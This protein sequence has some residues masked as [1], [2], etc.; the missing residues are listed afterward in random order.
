V[1]TVL[2]QGSPLPAPVVLTP[3][4]TNPAGGLEQ[5]ERYEGMRVQVDSL[6]VV[7]P[8][9]GS[10]SEASALGFSNGVFYGVLTGVARPFR[11]PGIDQID[12]LPPGSPCCVPRF[13]TNPERLRVDSDALGAP[14]L[15]VTS[16][17]VVSNLVGELDYAFRTWTIL[18][19]P[20]G[21]PTVTGITSATPVPAA[22]INEFTIASFNMQRFYDTT[23]DPDTSDGVL[24]ATGLERRLQKASLA[25]RNV[26]RM[27]DIIGVQEVENL[28]TL[29]TLA[30]RINSD[31][32]AAGQPN[33]NYIPYLEE[34]NDIGGIDV[35]LLVKL[36]RVAVIEVI[37]EGKDATYI[38]PNNGQSELLNDRPP[39]VLRA[40]ILS[41]PAPN[42]PI[43]AIVNHLRSFLDINDP[44]DG[45]RV[46]T[47]RRAQAEF[48]ANL[49]QARQAADPNE[50]IVL[51]GDFNSYQFSDGY[52]D[53][54]GIIRGSPASDDQVVLGSTD[55]VD[56]DLINLVDRADAAERYSYVFDGSA[57]VLD[58]ILMTSNM[59]DSFSRFHYARNDADFPESYR[60]DQ[61]R[62][63]RISDH[64]MPV[65]YFFLPPIEVQV[66]IKPGTSPNTIN[67]GSKGTVPVAILSTPEFDAGQVDPSTVTLASAPV[68]LKGNGMPQA[69]LEDVNGDGLRD[70]VIHVSTSALQLTP[71][72]VEAVLE[73]M[74][75]DG[76]RIRGTDTVVIVP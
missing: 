12:P 41:P 42:F 36:S 30:D 2:G 33:P 19:E 59:E 49:V 76:R 29:Q 64:D 6:T 60:S 1:V 69:S 38:N 10:V 65:A 68:A 25:I 61:T 73:G 74:T 23:N 54:M 52:V 50:H 70:L 53:T 46:R 3:A 45:N 51:A 32:M 48:L 31:A 28:S 75:Y 47:K 35:G 16:G 20:G 9:A 66:D 8:T 22:G 15:E 72:S 43:T 56:P 21:A 4:D 39:L 63:E 18:P 71:T 14:A 62:P 67:L 44:V 34:G 27:P 11:E 26:M 40:E 5:I 57:Q 24:N 37:Q 7:A 55:L 13:D 17:A 58:Q